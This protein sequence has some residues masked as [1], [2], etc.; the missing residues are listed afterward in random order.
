MGLAKS[1]HKPHETLPKIAVRFN[2][3]MSAAAGVHIGKVMIDVTASPRPQHTNNCLGGKKAPAPQNGQQEAITL[4][5]LKMQPTLYFRPDRSYI[6]TGGLGGF[7][8]SM[9]EMLCEYGANNIVLTSKRGVT[10]GNQ[11]IILQTLYTKK[12]NVS[13]LFSCLCGSTMFHILL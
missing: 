12:K 3:N 7:G 4:P 13:G 2:S 10:N 1:W 9:F 8:I 11:Q 5:P 6:I